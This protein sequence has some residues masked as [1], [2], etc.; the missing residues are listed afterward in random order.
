MKRVLIYSVF[1]S[2]FSIQSQASSMKLELRA[3]SDST[4]YNKASGKSDSHGFVL[5]T[6]RV[7]WKGNPSDAFS[8][9]FRLRLNNEETFRGVDGLSSRIDHASVTH[10]LDQVSLSFGRMATD[11]GGFETISESRDL[12]LK[13]EANM[14]LTSTYDSI[15]SEPAFFQ[16]K[17]ATGVKAQTSLG[18]FGDL[19]IMVMNNPEAEVDADDDSTTSPH[20]QKRLMQGLVWKG[21]FRD[22][23]I[24]PVLSHH[25]YGSNMDSGA[26]NGDTTTQTSSAG[27]RWIKEGSFAQ[28]DY[29][30]LE[31]TPL[32][33]PT[34]DT[35]FQ[36]SS[37]VGEVGYQMGPWTTRFKAEMSTL[38]ETPGAGSKLKADVKG[39]GLAAE[40]QVPNIEMARYHIAMTQKI[41]SQESAEDKTET[42]LIAGI[43]IA[44]D[45]F[46]DGGQ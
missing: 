27:L 11:A 18:S 45:L 16:M 1:L 19:A 5:Q 26:S 25:R 32:T 35:D 33:A 36:V 34:A 29:V 4:D 13:S 44:H 30:L 37:L 6:A 28:I 20:A 9:R 22:G 7:D 41:R 14:A 3:D 24:L 39:Y 38:T 2:L 40:Y 43:V 17:Y 42:H 46:K 8:Y 21:K 10:Q 12:Y 15:S 31:T 23:E